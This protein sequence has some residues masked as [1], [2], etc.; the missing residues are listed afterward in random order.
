MK[1]VGKRVQHHLTEPQ[2]EALKTRSRKTGVTVSEMVRR[3]V[4]RYLA[5]VKA[6][7]DARY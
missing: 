6:E 5:A 1:K 2:I 7:R 4:D 3:A